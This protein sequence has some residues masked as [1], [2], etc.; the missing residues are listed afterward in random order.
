MQLSN[1]EARKPASLPVTD[2][3]DDWEL[4]FQEPDDSGESEES[5]EDVHEEICRSKW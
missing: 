3:L 4:K 5:E 1:Q 2:K